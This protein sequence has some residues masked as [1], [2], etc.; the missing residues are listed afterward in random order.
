MTPAGDESNSRRGG[1]PWAF[2]LDPAANAAALTG[3]QRQ[4]L[5]AA[6]RLVERAISG[7]DRSTGGG[8]A[9][10]DA[11]RGSGE[12]PDPRDPI[13]DLLGYW[14]ELTTQVLAKLAEGREP[15]PRDRT[16]HDGRITV[17]IDGSGPPGSIRLRLDDDPG[18]R[19]R[20]VSEFWLRNPGERSVGP[21]DLHLD[22]LHTPDGHKL[23]GGSVAFD[24]PVIH[25]LAPGSRCRVGVTASPRRRP[26][27]GNYRGIVQSAGAPGLV[28][29]LE[30][31]QPPPGR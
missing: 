8:P 17:A 29:V 16:G 21:V 25:E 14:T 6:R 19:L 13:G 15:P 1:L 12:R 23:T 24:P 26:A 30:V 4:G 20:A 11:R 31:E 10:S 27:P 18:G 5:D 2:V 3:V 28:L 7:S 22:E 9:G